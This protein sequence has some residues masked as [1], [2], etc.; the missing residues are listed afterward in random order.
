MRYV[1]SVFLLLIAL[2]VGRAAW[3]RLRA[4]APATRTTEV[5][6]LTPTRPTSYRTTAPPVKQ[7]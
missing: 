4:P 3:V 7:T 5:A 2:L 1:W 6:L